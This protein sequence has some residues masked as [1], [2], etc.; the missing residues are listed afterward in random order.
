MGKTQQKTAEDQVEKRI[1]LNCQL[2]Q[3]DYAI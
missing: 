3:Y 2:A 1:A